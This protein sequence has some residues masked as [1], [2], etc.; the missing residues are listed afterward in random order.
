VPMRDTSILCDLY[1]KTDG[2][3]SVVA[4]GGRKKKEWQ[5]AL[6]PFLPIWVQWQGDGLCRLTHCERMGAGTDLQGHR[7]FC[8]FYVNELI[9][10]LCPQTEGNAELFTLYHQT[11][12]ALRHQDMAQTL[13]QFERHF[14]T[15]LGYGIA[16]PTHEADHYQYDPIKGWCPAHPAPHTFSAAMVEAMTH[17]HWHVTGALDAAKR[18]YRT[19][20]DAL[21]P[22]PLQSRSLF[23]SIQ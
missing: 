13:R 15:L 1:T 5:G 7:L 17:E 23:R 14:L 18:L 8:G 4:R 20:F 9:S 3:V 21:L 16:P 11:I 10:K 2:K 6:Q 22:Y 12:Q 19:I